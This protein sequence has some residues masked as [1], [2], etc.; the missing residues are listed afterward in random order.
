MCLCSACSGEWINDSDRLPVTFYK[1]SQSPRPYEQPTCNISPEIKSMLM[2]DMTVPRV[3]PPQGKFLMTALCRRWMCQN[4][5]E[6]ICLFWTW[7]TL[8]AWWQNKLPWGLS[9]FAKK[10]TSKAGQLFTA[11]IPLLAQKHTHNAAVWLL[12]AWLL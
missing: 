5:W 1:W 10:K 4:C 2:T 9:C 12:V 6:K 7:K 8:L 11:S 3:L